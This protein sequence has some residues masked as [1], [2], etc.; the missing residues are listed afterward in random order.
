MPSILIN[1]VLGKMGRM[2][3]QCAVES[4]DP[5]AAG[6]DRYAAG[7]TASYPLF[8]SLPACTAQADVL[9]DFSR[10]DA[11]DDILAYALPRKMPLVMAT[12]GYTQEQEEKI[13]QAAKTLPI[14]KT[15]NM[16]LG[17][18]V[19]MN[20]A[21]QAASALGGYDIE[22]VETHHNTKVDAPSGT[23]LLLADGIR[24]ALPDERTYVFGRHG[25]QRRSKADIGIHALRGGT[26]AGEHEI[27][28]FG[29]DETVTLKHTAASR[30]ILAIGALKAA[31]YI[32]KQSAG[33]YSMRDL[34]LEN[35]GVTHLG[36]QDKQALLT[37]PAQADVPALLDELAR[38]DVN[39]DMIAQSSPDAPFSFTIDASALGGIQKLLANVNATVLPDCV[40]LTVCGEG[41]EKQRG[42]ASAVFAELARIGARP[43]L[44]T[45]SETQI[46]LL[47]R[48]QDEQKARAA[49]AKKWNFA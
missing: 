38:L 18:N 46:S 24:D 13:R 12:T 11:L 3:V 7:A 10:P 31:N 17:V 15:A 1:G 48:P 6:V 33:L 4:G 44:I 30:R 27:F 47:L 2:I 9:I 22:I 49:L 36:S 8:E 25:T 32:V 34:L 23:A 42:I 29:D 14:F 41:M 39:V 26:V 5:V 45:T 43:L 20:L 40:K 19:L 37:L 35:A 16:S 28:F 21:K